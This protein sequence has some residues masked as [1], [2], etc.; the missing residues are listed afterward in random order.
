MKISRRQKVFVIGAALI[1]WTSLVSIGSYALYS[2]TVTLTDNTITTGT[3]SLLISNSQNQSST[4]YEEMRQGFLA[5][6]IPGKGTTKYFLVKNASDADV[7]FELYVSTLT[8]SGST[9]IKDAVNLEIVP[10]DANGDDL[11]GYA[12]VVGTLTSLSAANVSLGVVLPRGTVQRFRLSTV[13]NS[14]FQA[15]SESAS[16]NLIINGVQAI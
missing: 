3:A 6:L 7:P 11:V 10:V 12:S 4:I 13:L 9:T 1:A 15:Q 2:D 16:Y 8:N 5:E 14:N